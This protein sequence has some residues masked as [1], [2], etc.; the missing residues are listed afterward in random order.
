MFKWEAV[1]VEGMVTQLPCIPTGC[2]ACCRETTMPV[3][4]AEAKRHEGHDLVAAV[5]V[6]AQGEGRALVLGDGQHRGGRRGHRR[7]HPD[8]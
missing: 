2:S 4:E 5:G 3:T 8:V 6:A 1:L 7:L